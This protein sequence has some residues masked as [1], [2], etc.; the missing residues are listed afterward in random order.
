[1]LIMKILGKVLLSAM[2][3]G[4]LTVMASDD[5]KMDKF[6]DDLM[7]KMTLEEKLGQINLPPGSD[8]VTGD[9]QSSDIGAAIVKGQVGGTFNIKGADKVKALQEL[10]VKKTRL[11]IPLLIGLDVIHGY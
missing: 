5:A 1:M 9:P 2:L 10:A 3:A 6:I 7:S 4:S 11:G 8:I